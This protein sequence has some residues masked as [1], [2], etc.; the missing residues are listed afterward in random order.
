MKKHVFGR[1]L[2][3]ERDTRRALFRS[4]TR[5]FVE[6]GQII[7]TKAKAKAVKPLIEKVLSL[8]LDGSV[9]SKRKAFS[10]LGND[11]KTIKKIF[12]EIV[13][14]FSGFKSGFVRIVDRGRR[15]GDFA[16]LARLEW[17]R[18]IIVAK[19]ELKKPRVKN[20]KK[21]EAKKIKK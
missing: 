12:N 21:T 18:E 15:A 17:T 1:K 5:S 11:K 7:T 4:L 14:S 8:C 9:A 6:N 10:L 16:I 13:P 2:S 3:R 20:G 19:K